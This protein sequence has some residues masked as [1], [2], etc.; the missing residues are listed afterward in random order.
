MKGIFS[1]G[2]IILTL[3]LAA[4][5]SMAGIEVG[6][7]GDTLMCRPAD[8]QRAE[9]WYNLDYYLTTAINHNEHEVREVTDWNDSL[10]KVQRVLAVNSPYLGYLF[11]EFLFYLGNSSDYSK[12]MIWEPAPRGLVVIHDEDIANLI[13]KECT[14]LVDGKPN[15]YQTV[16]RQENP[17]ILIFAFDPHLVDQLKRNFPVQYSFLIVHEWLWSFSKRTDTLRRV[18]RFLHSTSTDRLTPEQFNGVLSNFGIT[19]NVKLEDVCQKHLLIRRAFQNEIGKN[20]QDILPDDFRRLDEIVIEN[21]VLHAIRPNDFFG[22]RSLR[23]LKI[24]NS[25]V[26]WIDPFAFSGMVN[27]DLVDLSNNRLREIELGVYSMRP[28]YVDLSNN[29]LTKVG[30]LNRFHFKGA[31][32]SNNQLTEIDPFWFQGIA[33]HAVMDFSRNQIVKVL[34]PRMRVTDFPFRLILTGNPLPAEELA[35]LKQALPTAQI[36]L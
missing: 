21:E 25:Q 33:P 5:T 30:H 36:E 10:R 27:L 34:K 1:V 9:S 7:G 23:R 24:T 31:N 35:K 19:A 14:K 22:T 12:A 3:I 32:F 2:S 28:A 20:C 16:V 8:S 26:E 18:N 13:P 29:Q 6:N 17:G 4:Q 15:I 11:D